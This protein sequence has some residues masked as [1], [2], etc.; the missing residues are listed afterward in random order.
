MELKTANLHLCTCMS[1]IFFFYC[2]F[3]QLYSAKENDDLDYFRANVLK[4]QK[5]KR[6]SA[7]LQR[8][9]IHITGFII[10]DIT[11]NARLL[12]SNP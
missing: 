4:Y 11:D 2:K 5:D 3:S 10:S 7:F 9:E 12:R 8:C 6:N 1:Y